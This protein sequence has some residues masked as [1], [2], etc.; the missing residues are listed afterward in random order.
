M[1]IV[2]WDPNLEVG[3]EHIDAQHRALFALLN[4][5]YAA[6]ENRTAEDVLLTTIK[7]LVTYSIE[8]FT[9]EMAFMAIKQYPDRWAHNFEHEEFQ[10]KIREFVARIYEGDIFFAK[11]VADFVHS[12]LVNH[13]ATVDAKLKGL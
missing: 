5:L 1:T 7:Q 12:W 2:S 6:I 10:R 9:S 11:E 13:I 3:I 4:N 8:H